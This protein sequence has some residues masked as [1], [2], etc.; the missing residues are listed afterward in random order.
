VALPVCI[1]L[2]LLGSLAMIAAPSL[3]LAAT[4]TFLIGAGFAA[5]FPVV[6][7]LVGDRYTALSGTAF[8]IVFVMALTGGSLLPYL[9][10][11]LGAEYGMRGSLLVVPACLVLQLALLVVVLRRST[12]VPV[13][14]LPAQGGA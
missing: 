13:T 8:S 2:A 6:L 12:A 5:A 1:A 10:G 3:P 11:V 9:T 14:T 4:G 7:G